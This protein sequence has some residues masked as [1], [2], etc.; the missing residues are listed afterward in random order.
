MA[1]V[2][3]AWTSA[4]VIGSNG[5]LAFGAGELVGARIVVA[6]ADRGGG[7]TCTVSSDDPTLAA[8]FQPVV[9]RVTLPDDSG[10]RRSIFLWSGHIGEDVATNPQITIAVRDTNDNPVDA[11]AVA[12]ATDAN[13]DYPLAAVASADSGTSTVTSQ[14]TGTTSVVPAGDVLVFTAASFRG[15]ATTSW[16]L[17]TSS[18]PNPDDP[19]NTWLLESGSGSGAARRECRL[20]FYAE[21]GAG[22]QAWVDTL[23]LSTAV[24]ASAVIAVWSTGAAGDQV[25]PSDGVH[26]HTATSP[27][28]T[29][30]HTLAVDSAVHGHTAGS[31]TVGQ[32]QHL[33]ADPA[34]HGH[35]ATTPTVGQAQTVTAASTVHGHTATSPPVVQVHALTANPASHGH[36]VTV[37][38]ISQTHQLTPADASHGHTATSPHV[39]QA[40]HLAADLT[41]H[42]HTASS[43]LL[44]QTHHLTPDLC[45]HGH[46]TTSPTVDETHLL[47][48][49]PAWHGH[50][51]TSAPLSA[52]TRL[53]PP[54]PATARSTTRGVTVW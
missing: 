12:A 42:G 21:T 25:A 9:E 31:T 22:V 27:T 38:V 43:P 11:S 4:T 45:T 6:V 20:G 41:S 51:T 46:T 29:Q 17:T 18:P 3:G 14:T 53:I 33:A 26:G 35:T 32:L 30:V 23:S 50:T 44:D 24:T 40:H 34:S 1:D 37:V 36:T 39:G 2:L 19:P 15:A 28:V 8:T 47:V 54:I 48:P 7:V 49:S 13:G 5:I 52:P 10:S 16:D